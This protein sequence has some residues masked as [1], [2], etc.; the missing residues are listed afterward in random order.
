M[1]IKDRVILSDSLEA[2]RPYRS[3]LSADLS[4]P[5]G[6]GC[7]AEHYAKVVRPGSLFWKIT[8]SRGSA[9][10][11]FAPAFSVL[12]CW[13]TLNFDL[14]DDGLVRVYSTHLTFDL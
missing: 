6:A 10:T 4:D 3:C 8:S 1:E 14:G 2:E 5:V 13:K 11:D 9:P 12:V 7:P